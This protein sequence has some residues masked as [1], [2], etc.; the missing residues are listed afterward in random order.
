MFVPFESAKKRNVCPGRDGIGVAV[1]VDVAVGVGFVP[2][3]LEDCGKCSRVAIGLLWFSLF[4]SVEEL[5]HR[6][7]RKRYTNHRGSSIFWNT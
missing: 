6:G 4:G 5:R 3:T 2:G 1:A 7:I